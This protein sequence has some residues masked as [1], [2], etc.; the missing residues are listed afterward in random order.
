MLSCNNWKLRYV[1]ER[2]FFCPV[3]LHFC[4]FPL[5]ICWFLVSGMVVVKCVNGAYGREENAHKTLDGEPTKKNIWKTRLH[6]SIALN[7][8]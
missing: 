4:S 6:G 1:G 2:F 8:S 7:I 5:N 3:T